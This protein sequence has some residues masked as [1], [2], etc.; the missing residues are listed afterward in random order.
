MPV[1][2]GPHGMMELHSRLNNLMEGGWGAFVKHGRITRLDVTVDLP[3]TKIDDFHFL[4]QK[5]AT[6]TVWRVNGKLTG[7]AHG[8]KEGN[9]TVI[10]DRKAKRIAQGKAWKGK[11]GA[12]IER[13]LRNTTLTL[14]DLPG[15]PN[16]FKGMSLVGMPEAPP[17]EQTKMV[18]VWHLFR[19]AADTHL[20]A[21]TLALLPPEK[22]TLYR[23]HLKA[24]EKSW[25]DPKAIWAH[26]PAM[27]DELKIASATAWK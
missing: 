9:Q 15:M 11:E 4:P 2:L 14:P 25:W 19:R 20:L 16:P 13:R 27:L 1:D 8:K 12:R 21:T 3:L 23:K 17:S 5:G 22:K 24:H 6:M 18:Y 26:W 7:Y 10:Y